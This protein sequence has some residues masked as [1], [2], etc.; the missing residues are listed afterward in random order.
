[1]ECPIDFSTLCQCYGTDGD[2][3]DTE[4]QECLAKE[5]CMRQT[6]EF[7][8]NKEMA[9]SKTSPYGHRTSALTGQIDWLLYKGA[10]LRDIMDRLGCSYSRL[11]QHLTKLARAG[12]KIVAKDGVGT[13]TVRTVT[14]TKRKGE[15]K[16]ETQEAKGKSPNGHKLGTKPAIIDVAM[17][18]LKTTD[19]W[20]TAEQVSAETGLSVGTVQKH[21]NFWREKGRYD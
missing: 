7:K 20:P 12:H 2:M 10:S 5:E 6:V 18:E 19:T 13:C 14:T 11:S 16:M 21:V 4:C 8:T 17:H 9:T 1:M 3:E 15:Q